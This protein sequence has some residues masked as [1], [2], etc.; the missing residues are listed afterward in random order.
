M[1]APVALVVGGGAL[2]LRPVLPALRPLRTGARCACSRAITLALA[3][4]TLGL[5]PGRRQR[6]PA[7]ELR[8]PAGARRRARRSALQARATRSCRALGV[9]I[10][11]VFLLLVGVILLTGASLAAALRAT[12]HGLL[13]TTRVVGRLG[14][15]G[16]T[17]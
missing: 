17:A 1:L 9:G 6:R 3:A 14:A 15:G 16:R 11:V 5:A 7:V 4:G 8:A 13:D 12:G 10:L 2:L